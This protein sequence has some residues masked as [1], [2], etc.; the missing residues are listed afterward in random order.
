MALSQKR[1]TQLAK[2][3]LIISEEKLSLFNAIL[4]K[5]GGLKEFEKAL[6]LWKF[7]GPKERVED[8]VSPEELANIFSYDEDG[9]VYAKKS[10]PNRKVGEKVG[11]LREN[12]ILTKVRFG[13][14]HFSTGLNKIVFCLHNGR[15]PKK[16]LEVDHING[17]TTDNR[18]CNLREGTKSQNGGNRSLGKNSTTGVKGVFYTNQ[19]DKL[20]NG[21]IHKRYYVS[22]RVK[23]D[24][25]TYERWFRRFKEFSDKILI[26][27]A[28]TWRD[29][30]SKEL[31][32]EFHRD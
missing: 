14:H 7:K 3:P 26:Q 13:D 5:V 30:K 12:Y 25:K 6:N 1:K 9:N 24:S 27:K 16:G 17:I 20:K 28:K 15:W 32:G 29:E 4:E 19:S 31:F 2:E 21:K 18:P 23:K 10:S 8:V 22:G 11:F